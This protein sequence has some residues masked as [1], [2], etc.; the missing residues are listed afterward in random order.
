MHTG[1]IVTEA[2]QYLKAIGNV[3]CSLMRSSEGFCAAYYLRSKNTDTV[4]IFGKT[5][6]S[7]PNKALGITAKPK[8]EVAGSGEHTITSPS[9]DAVI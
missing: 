8:V 6:L 3:T 9:G 7:V 5:M 4:I 1:T 2:L